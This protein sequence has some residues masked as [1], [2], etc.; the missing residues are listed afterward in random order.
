MAE[1]GINSIVWHHG[2]DRIDVIY[3]EGDTDRLWGSE[4]VAVVLANNAGLTAVSA[5][6]GTRRWVRDPDD[7]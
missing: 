4:S 7:P 1:R 3:V 2:R 5:P 6:E